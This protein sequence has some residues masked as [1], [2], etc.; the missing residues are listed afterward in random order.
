MHDAVRQPCIRRHSLQAVHHSFHH[1]RLRRIFTFTFSVIENIAMA[2]Y[3][4]HQSQS[5]SS[6]YA[7]EYDFIFGSRLIRFASLTAASVFS[8]KL[9]CGGTMSNGI[10]CWLTD[11]FRN[12]RIAV[13]V[14]SPSESNSTAYGGGTSLLPFKINLNVIRFYKVQAPAVLSQVCSLS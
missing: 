11:C 3:I 4:N 13:V 9:S 5:S 10:R 8:E 14:S 1:A 7:L 12:S 6:S 2:A